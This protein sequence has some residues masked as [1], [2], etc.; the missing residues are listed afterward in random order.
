MVAVG[1]VFLWG[2]G[3]G[4]R[5]CALGSDSCALLR[6]PL[7]AQK[8]WS[9]SICR[10]PHPGPPL[11]RLLA[12]WREVTATW[13]GNLSGSGL[14]SLGGAGT[15]AGHGA[16]TFLAGSWRPDVHTGRE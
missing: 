4:S 16:Q 3:G 5:G 8:G 12:L 6:G 14:Q 7:S 15:R 10:G 2:C 9:P 11:S 1:A 13:A